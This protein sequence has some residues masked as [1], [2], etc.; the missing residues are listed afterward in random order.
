MT[1]PLELG[2][3]LVA[4]KLV[5]KF[6]E[7]LESEV[8]EGFLTLL[9]D[10][11]A[12]VLFFN[13]RYRENIKR[14]DACYV[15]RTADDSMVVT[16]I[17]RHDRLEVWP[18]RRKDAQP[19]IIITFQNPKALRNLLLAPKADILGSMLRQEVRL[20]GNLNYLYKLAYMARRL[21]LIA[22]RAV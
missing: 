13:A 5:E 2:S 22:T 7:C 17:F 12:A 3:N 6:R 16:A 18:H 21:Q 9:L 15:L 8:A 4:D 11:M 20:E 1:H 10:L 19:N 14:F